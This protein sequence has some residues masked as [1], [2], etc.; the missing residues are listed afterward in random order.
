MARCK[1][2]IKSIK[3][4]SFKFIKS[5]ICKALIFLAFISGASNVNANN[6]KIFVVAKVNNQIITNLDLK[7]RF[8]FFT[9]TSNINITSD[10]EK[11][12]ILKQLIQKLIEEKLQVL[13]AKD[14]SITVP[15]E[16][17]NKALE[18]I[19]ASQG[20]STKQIKNF[21]KKKRISYSEY[22]DQIKMQL[23]WKKI[24]NKAVASGIK[25]TESEISEMVELQ[26]MDVKKISLNLAE[27]FI[28]FN[29]KDEEEKSLSLAKKLV[30]EIDKDGNFK[31]IARQF[32]R[33]ASSEFDGEIGWIEQSSLDKRIYAGIENIKIGNISK[34]IKVA[35]GY[36]IFKILG[37][38]I[39]SDIKEGD[40]KQL[41]NLIFNKKL[42]IG[43]KSYLRDLRK[44]SYIRILPLLASDY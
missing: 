26:N 33:S 30:D 11:L 20:Q 4:P 10:S 21:F 36:Y 6:S 5:L 24:I 38:K 1:Y 41:K 18:N 17:L 42:K 31:D 16:E 35:D 44:K 15:D 43:A 22:V 28:P 32:S 3:A 14:L 7:R 29:G 23:L 27:I 2:I 19:S 13:Q 39:V 12:F 9:R 40:L 25:I 34:A 37:K 8:N